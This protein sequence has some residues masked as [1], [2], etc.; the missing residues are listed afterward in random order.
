MH[1]TF[2]EN[3]E[4]EELINFLPGHNKDFIVNTSPNGNQT[5]TVKKK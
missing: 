5:E 1:E 3:Q 2:I 4:G